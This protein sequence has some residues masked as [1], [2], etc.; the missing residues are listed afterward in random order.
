M[1]ELNAKDIFKILENLESNKNINNFIIT[2]HV[3]PDGD[4]IGSALGMFE[5]L[6]KLNKKARIIN[7]SPTPNELKFLDRNNIIEHF[8]KQKHSELFDKNTC[9]IIVDLNDPK[10]LGEIGDLCLESGEIIVIDH[11][12]FPKAF[13]N[14]YF[15]DVN[16]ASTAE[17]IW[18]I[19]QESKQSLSKLASE[20]IYVGIMTDTGSFR[21][22]RTVAQTF[23]ICADLLDH[24]A[25]PEYLYN[26]IY[27]RNSYEGLKLLGV[28]LNSIELHYEGK[29][30]IMPLPKKIFEETGASEDD[31]EGFSSQGLKIEGVKVAITITEIK[32]RDELRISFRSRDGISIRELA[33]EFGGGGHGYASGA[34][35]E[36]SNFDEMKAELIESAK[37]LF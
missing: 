14:H 16:S 29:L 13:A 23:R 8:E 10:R 26:M 34:R 1:T 20:A 28:A 22:D 19:W 7:I 3:N 25:D 12:L 35:V 30:A 17:I 36:N 11:H 24:G 31:T 2:T 18:K 21:Y 15:M 32:S 27:N 5:L 6:I 37:V 9:V 33:E 4:A